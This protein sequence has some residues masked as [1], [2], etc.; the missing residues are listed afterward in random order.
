[1]NLHYV[2]SYLAGL[3]GETH[4]YCEDK[5]RELVLDIREYVKKEDTLESVSNILNVINSYCID[6][7]RLVEEFN[8]MAKCK[9][10]IR[11]RIDK[12]LEITCVVSCL[13]SY[14]LNILSREH[15]KNKG[16]DDKGMFR[17]IAEIKEKREMMKSEKFT[18]TEVLRVLRN[19][20]WT[21]TKK[22]ELDFEKEKLR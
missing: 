7:V 19:N 21:E 2:E 16:V 22:Q 6:H 3:I 5:I 14:L 11:T 9:K 8:A 10:D 1:M 20:L 12:A 15:L 18:W 17:M 4:K 13:D